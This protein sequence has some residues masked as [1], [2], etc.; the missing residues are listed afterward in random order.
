MPPNRRPPHTTSPAYEQPYA[1]SQETEGSQTQAAL[2]M[3]WCYRRQGG[4]CPGAIRPAHSRFELEYFQLCPK[5]SRWTG[6]AAMNAPMM[7]LN[8][9]R[10]LLEKAQVKAYWRAPDP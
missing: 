10:L 6:H 1:A 4:E 9:E 8:I 5:Y 2:A 7:N 3:G